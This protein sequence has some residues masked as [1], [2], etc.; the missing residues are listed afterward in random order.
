MAALGLDKK[1]RRITKK[2]VTLLGGGLLLLCAIIFGVIALLQN[3]NKQA[4]A[5]TIYREYTV[6]YGDIILGQT[7]SSS[8]SLNRE[9]VTFPVSAAVEE[10]YVKAGSSVKTGDPLIRLNT[11][12]I[13]AGLKS[14]DLQLEIM[15][16]EVEQAKLQLET[17]LLQAEQQLES[18]KEAGSLAKDNRDLSIAEL[19]LALENAQTSLSAAQE[20][21]SKYS[22]LSVTFES[23]YNR[24]NSLQDAVDY[25]GE[26]A[27]DLQSAANSITDYSALRKTAEEEL[28]SAWKQL[29]SAAVNLDNNST[30][31]TSAGSPSAVTLATNIGNY[32]S[33]HTL[34]PGTIDG[35]S[36]TTYSDAQATIQGWQNI[37]GLDDTA[38]FTVN[39]LL[40][41]HKTMET[42]AKN[43][44]DYTQNASGSASSAASAE[45][46][47]KKAQSLQSTYQSEYNSFKTEFSDKYGNVQDIDELTKKIATLTADV[48]TAELNLTKA[49]I[50]AQTG[51][52][53]AN[54]KSQ[55]ALNEASTAKTTYELTEME[56]AQTVEAAQERYDQLNSQIE[57]AR[58]ALTDDGIVYATVNGMVSS[59]NVVVG[60]SVSVSIDSET[61]RLSQFAQLLTMTNVSDVYVPITISEEDI[62]SISIGQEASVTMAAFPGETFAAEVDTIS[63]EA[64]RT[65]AATVSY[66]VVVR[67]AGENDRDML[68]G[69]SASVTLIQRAVRD[70]LYVN[71][72]AVTNTDGVSIVLVKG[73]DDAGVPTTVKTGFTDGQFVEIVSGLSEGDVV[74]AESAVGRQ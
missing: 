24:L 43:V 52:T 39:A 12:D 49:G 23:D 57:E 8:I 63:V 70:V 11:D 5:S 21:L 58:G 3:S 67:F 4:S 54:Q 7:E 29:T 42:Q 22:S 44:R 28:T 17:R 46:A 33:M 38:K 55:S 56:L 34:A 27:S 16:L 10:I 53:S 31:N 47:L 71:A 6:E 72:Q 41:A 64:S 9:T 15:A 14:Y 32:Y 62:L 1:T 30:F 69:M 37:S 40:N 66:T 65:G 61:K 2:R 26:Q 35:S 50:S 60:D 13:E 51:E 20:D 19:Q 73:E 74:L 36:G 45:A 18:S 59:V 68:E 48:A 25:W